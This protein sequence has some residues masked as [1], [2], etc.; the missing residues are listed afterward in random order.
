MYGI[1]LMQPNAERNESKA[2]SRTRKLEKLL[3][4]PPRHD[5][6]QHDTNE[7]TCE[8]NDERI[9]SLIEF[10]IEICA[11]S[12]QLL[13]I[14]PCNLEGTN[15]SDHDETRVIHD[16][17][18]YYTEKFEKLKQALLDSLHLPNTISEKTNS[19]NDE[20]SAPS[21]FQKDENLELV[22]EKITKT[23]DR[24]VLRFWLKKKIIPLK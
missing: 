5:S 22:V 1:R 3:A 10:K 2:S 8:L 23:N 21:S 16:R 13:E 9:L 12:Q 4:E 20:E 19:N 15:E 6:I 24:H 18:K 14:Q 17:I 11:L 7:H